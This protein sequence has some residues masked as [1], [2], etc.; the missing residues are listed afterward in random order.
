MKTV[1]QDLDEQRMYHLAYPWMNSHHLVICLYQLDI[2]ELWYLDCVWKQYMLCFFACR[3]MVNI[4]C[5]YEWTFASVTCW[6]WRTGN[7]W[8]R[9]NILY[10]WSFI[11][12]INLPGEPGGP[13]KPG[14]NSMRRVEIREEWKNL[15]S[16][17]TNITNGTTSTCWTWIAYKQETIIAVS[18]LLVSQIFTWA[19]REA[20]LTWK[21][22]LSWKTSCSW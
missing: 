16:T 20:N 4:P 19:T 9:T 22:F 12:R 13:Y 14:L 1:Y 10:L 6:T 8:R 21:T 5:E 17:L 15:L 3:S 11:R 18:I 7:T 2:E